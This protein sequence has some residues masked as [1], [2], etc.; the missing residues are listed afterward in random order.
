MKNIGAFYDTIAYQNIDKWYSNTDIISILSEFLLHCPSNPKILEIG[1]GIGQNCKILGDMGVKEIL[2]IDIS[3]KSLEIA[4]KMNPAH[5]FKFMD[6][7]DV[8]SNI[9][10]FNGVISL[11]SM[12]HILQNELQSVLRNIF[13]IM[14]ESGVFL[15]VLICGNEYYVE[16]R[17]VVKYDESYKYFFVTYNKT[18]FITAA[19][20]SGLRFIQE[21]YYPEN[22]P[23]SAWTNL[24][25]RR[26]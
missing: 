21:L 17:E 18:E 20:V 5:R 6:M 22:S 25:F 12:V 23:L 1:C 3:E 2:G 26:K 24:L 7:K 8:N 16:N 4:R 15:A 10:L 14:T 13:S 11:A 9:G 19:E